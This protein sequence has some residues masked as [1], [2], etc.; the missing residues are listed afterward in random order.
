MFVEDYLELKL[1]DAERVAQ[2]CFLF[3]EFIENFLNQE[4]AALQFND[5]SERMVIHPHCHAK[6]LTNP[7]LMR[8]LAE[9]LPKR[10]V[11]LLDS[12]C[13]GM[14][15]AFGML[16]SKYELSLK[17]AEPL[18][19]KIRNQPY[20]TIVVASGTSCRQQI[21]HLAPVK[22]RHMAEVLADALA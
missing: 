12:G 20:G 14:A 6:A 5:K 13:C 22:I 17:V 4:P 15:G 16:E 3:E 21:Q 1:P 8:Q 9:R 18:I 19:Q 7:D 2:R 11:T 10:T